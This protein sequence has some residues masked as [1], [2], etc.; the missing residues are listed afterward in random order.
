MSIPA[1]RLDTR[2][3]PRYN[4]SVIGSK[5]FL[6]SR[7]ELLFATDSKSGKGTKQARCAYIWLA[8]WKEQPQPLTQ[9]ASSVVQEYPVLLLARVFSVLP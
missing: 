5:R 4:G 7:G 1:P 6:T 8:G 3:S 9:E 2:V